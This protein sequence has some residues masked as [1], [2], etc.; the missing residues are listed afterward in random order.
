MSRKSG[1][2]AGDVK[3]SRFPDYQLFPGSAAIVVRQE[4]EGKSHAAVSLRDNRRAGWILTALLTLLSLVM[5]LSKVV[6]DA[7]GLSAGQLAAG[8]EPEVVSF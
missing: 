4:A 8:A 1:E 6:L 3:R 5:A 7:A 2:T